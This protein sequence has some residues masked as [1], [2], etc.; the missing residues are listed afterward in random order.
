LPFYRSIMDVDRRAAPRSPAHVLF[1]KYIDGVPYLCEAL[2]I[3]MT[4]MLVRTL[5]GPSMPHASYAVELAHPDAN[6][7][8]VLDDDDAPP[9]RLWLCAVP[10]WT[11]GKF[12]ALSFVSQSRLDRLRLA[13]LIAALRG[14]A[15]PTRATSEEAYLP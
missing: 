6:G 12:Q 4:G 5:H 2:E 1:K 9:R 11:H 13:D 10:V 8:D 3:S 14:P 7:A 15:C